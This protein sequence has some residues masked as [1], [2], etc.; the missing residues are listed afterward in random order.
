MDLLY[1]ARAVFVEQPW[2]DNTYIPEDSVVEVSCLG[3]TGQSPQW[4]I[5]LPGIGVPS[6]FGFQGSIPL[7]NSRGIYQKESELDNSN[8]I[9]L[10]INNTEDINGTEIQCD[11][12]I[13]ATTIS[14]TV[15]IVYGK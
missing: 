3:G 5:Y 10:H 11:D 15:L 13:T 9:L 7:L 2:E 1:I 14:R 8:R 12:L 4:S 6:Q